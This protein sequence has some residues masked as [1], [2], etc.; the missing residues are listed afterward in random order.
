MADSNVFILF[1]EIKT[2]LKGINGKL[3]ELPSVV[4]QQPKIG[5]SQ[6]D[7]SP[8][9]N[10][11]VETT[12]A[13]S[14]DIKGLLAKQWKAYAQLSS[15][16]LQ[17]LDTIKKSQNEQGMLQEPQPQEHIHRHSF[18][19]KSNKVFSF[20]VGIGVICTL[21]LCGNIA[22][23]QSKRQYADDAL[24]FRAI[25]SWGGCNANDV[26]WLNK[27]FDLHRDEK[28]I[29]WIRKQ[30]NGYEISLK[31]VSDSLMQESIQSK[32]D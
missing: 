27:V 4:N 3:E 2:A 8:I 22:Q 19:I 15:V 23:W 7:L 26:L 29:K 18:D 11:I 12:K 28:A 13:Q 24:K 20:V 31:A 14:E 6:Q 16:I 10:V 1:E 32:S 25:R 5:D 9:K 17:Q 21:S 30:A